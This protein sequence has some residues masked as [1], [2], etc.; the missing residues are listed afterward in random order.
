M[1]KTEYNRTDILCRKRTA[2]RNVLVPR[3]ETRRELWSRS[4][5]VQFT[6]SSRICASHFNDLDF[7]Y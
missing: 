2:E 4:T 5:G 6:R 7:F 3:A 1:S